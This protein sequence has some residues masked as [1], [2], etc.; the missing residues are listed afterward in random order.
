MGSLFDQTE[1]FNY[2]KRASDKEIKF[3]FLELALAYYDGLGTSKNYELALKYF[4]KAMAQ[5]YIDKIQS[6]QNIIIALLY[7]YI[8]QNLPK[9]GSPIF[10]SVIFSPISLKNVIRYLADDPLL[11]QWI[12][13]ALMAHFRTNKPDFK[14]EVIDQWYDDFY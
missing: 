12:T 7:D 4:Q 14:Q 1:A 8:R 3:A 6:Y 2:F 9:K 5:S 13:E 11:R 10:S